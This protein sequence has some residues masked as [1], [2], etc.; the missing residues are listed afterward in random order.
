MTRA[1]A[2]VALGAIS[3]FLCACGY[4]YAPLTVEVR[5]RLNEDR[6][7]GARVFIDYARTIN[8][9]PPRTAEGVTDDEGRVTLEAAIYN[10][11]VVYV[12]PPEG[13]EH[14]FAADH[15]AAHG[16]TNWINTFTDRRGNPARVVIRMI[17]ASR[18][19]LPAPEEP[20]DE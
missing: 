15:P 13:T 14:V 1:I 18:S 6:V 20:S 9:S 7:G 10:R 2:T 16:A 8:P 5:S 11:L 3:L 4:T 19:E 17:P 12:T